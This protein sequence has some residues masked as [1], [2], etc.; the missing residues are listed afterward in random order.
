MA[1]KTKTRA[2]A[3]EFPQDGEFLRLVDRLATVAFQERRNFT[4]E[5]MAQAFDA[6]KARLGEVYE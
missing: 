2:K 6:A 4:R 3:P 5:R 1:T